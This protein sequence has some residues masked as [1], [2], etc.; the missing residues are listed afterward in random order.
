[1]AASLSMTSALAGSM[2]AR[3]TGEFR[4]RSERRDKARRALIFLRA[5]AL[6]APLGLAAGLGCHPPLPSKLWVYSRKTCLMPTQ[7]LVKS[8]K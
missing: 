7:Q 3:S 6:S 5:W 1:M 8:L 2:V 4:S